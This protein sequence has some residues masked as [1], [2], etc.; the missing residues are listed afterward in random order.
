MC[1]FYENLGTSSEFDRCNL[2][3]HKRL[4][5]PRFC[6]EECP[7]YK[8]L[9]SHEEASKIIETRQPHGKFYEIAGNRFIG[10]DNETGDA[11]TEEFPNLK[12]CIDWLF[13]C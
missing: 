2:P 4:L 5:W 3:G 9:I 12:D 10:I 8:I 13:N 7:L 1:Q 6:Q 11:W